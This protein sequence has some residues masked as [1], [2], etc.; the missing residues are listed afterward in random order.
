MN[1]RSGMSFCLP[2]IHEVGRRHVF[3]RCSQKRTEVGAVFITS[4]RPDLLTQ[5]SLVGRMAQWV[6]GSGGRDEY[7]PYHGFL[8]K[9]EWTRLCSMS[10]TTMQLGCKGIENPM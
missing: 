7:G 3:A 2:C 10:I 6:I 9:K 5:P 1:K 8:L 4:D